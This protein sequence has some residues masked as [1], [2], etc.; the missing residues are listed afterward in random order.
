MFQLTGYSRVNAYSAPT[1]GYP[2]PAVVSLMTMEVIRLGKV[3]TYSVPS[4]C[5]PEVL[6]DCGDCLG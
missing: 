5:S 6:A 2:F 4:E 3:E 1:A